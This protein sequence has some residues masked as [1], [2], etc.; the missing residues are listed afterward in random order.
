M[1]NQKQSS[2]FQTVARQIHYYLPIEALPN[3]SKL[4]YILL[5]MQACR[6]VMHLYILCN[7]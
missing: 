6:G 4:R 3:Y 2:L 5:I 7:L 1:A